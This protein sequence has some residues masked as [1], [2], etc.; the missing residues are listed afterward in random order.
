MQNASCFGAWEC[1]KT[2]QLIV[3]WPKKGR[4]TIHLE[5]MNKMSLEIANTFQVVYEILQ[6]P[7]IQSKDMKRTPKDAKYTEHRERFRTLMAF[8]R[9]CIN[10]NLQC[11]ITIDIL[12]WQRS[13]C[14]KVS[15]SSHCHRK[16]NRKW[17]MTYGGNLWI[18]LSWSKKS[19][20]IV[21][22]QGIGASNVF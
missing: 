6:V 13:R 20:E 22:L 18:R 17:K 9:W 12:Y 14:C 5:A 21:L 19:L 4:G 3:K 16:K 11:G 15:H 8:R 2:L 7:N 10:V 1:L